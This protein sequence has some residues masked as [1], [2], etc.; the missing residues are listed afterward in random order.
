LF[1]EGVLRDMKKAKSDHPGYKHTLQ[2]YSTSVEKSF[3]GSHISLMTNVLGGTVQ[4]LRR[5]QPN[6]NLGIPVRAAKRIVK[7]TL[8]A[9]D[10]L[11]RECKYVHT[12]IDFFSR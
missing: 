9:L 5:L 4:T 11:H 8:L 10:F 3:H 12:G 7:Q 1:G 6:G 2:L